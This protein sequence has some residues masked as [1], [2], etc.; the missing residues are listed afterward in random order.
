MANPKIDLE[1]A[2][3]PLKDEVAA[4]RADLAELAG[5]VTRIGKERAQGLKSA[6]N[7]AAAEGYARGEAAVDVMMSELHSL[8]EELAD[9]TRRRPFAALGLA[10]LFGFLIGVLFRR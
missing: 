6:A 9:A 5:V 2:A 1:A 10:A 7:N 4:L 3:E 8:E